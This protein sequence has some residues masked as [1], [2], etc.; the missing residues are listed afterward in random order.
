MMGEVSHAE[1]N[2]RDSYPH[3]V[4]HTH[5]KAVQKVPA[6]ANFGNYPRTKGENKQPK[7]RFILSGINC[8]VAKDIINPKIDN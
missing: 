7:H 8:M 6:G 5:Q 3:T 4:Y 2:V 1:Y